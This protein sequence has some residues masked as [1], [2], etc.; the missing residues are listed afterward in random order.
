MNLSVK[1]QVTRMVLIG[2]VYRIIESDDPDRQN[3]QQGGKML[4]I[5]NDNFMSLD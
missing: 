1:L 2:I 5:W 3:L 4:S